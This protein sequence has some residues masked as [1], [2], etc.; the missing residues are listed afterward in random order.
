MF[1]PSADRRVKNPLCEQQNQ[2]GK[3]TN[4]N[5]H[6]K[7]M[8]V[9]VTWYAKQI[10]IGK[11]LLIMIGCKEKTWSVW[12]YW[13]SWASTCE[14]VQLCINPNQPAGINISSQQA[15]NLTNHSKRAGSTANPGKNFCPPNCGSGR[16]PDARRLWQTN[17]CIEIETKCVKYCARGSRWLH[18]RPVV[19]PEHLGENFQ[20]FETQANII[21]IKI[22]QLIKYHKTS[23]I[24]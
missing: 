15:A 21:I 5:I 22:L 20:T 13:F 6:I 1:L 16:R 12:T 3:Q 11:E 4:K 10:Q 19:H 17:C 2:V 23:I 14:S 24:P 9:I 8:K 18:A 7:M